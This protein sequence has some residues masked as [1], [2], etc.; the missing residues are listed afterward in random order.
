[1]R[2]FKTGIYRHFKGREY[3][4]IDI[5]IHSETRE[6]FVVYKALY[7]DFK[8]FIRPYDMFM[9]KVDKEKYPDIKQKY[10]FEYIDG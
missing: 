7:G 1:M 6:K 9:S 8:T 5:A 3:E 2:E 10:R 4:V